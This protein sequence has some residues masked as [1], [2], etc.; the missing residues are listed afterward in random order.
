M[1]LIR[2]HPLLFEDV[3]SKVPVADLLWL[4]AARART[5]EDVRGI[6]R[7]LDDMSTEE[8]GEA[9]KSDIA[10]QAC[11]F[12]ADRCWLSMDA[13]PKEEQDWNAVLQVLEELE[14]LAQRHGLEELRYMA[15]QG[16]AVVLSDYLSRGN[17]GLQLLRDAEEPAN[18]NCLFF[19]RYRIARI[20]DDLN[21][22]KEAIDEY[23]RALDSGGRDFVYLRFRTYIEATVACGRIGNWEK[24]A[25]WARGGLAFASLYPKASFR[26]FEVH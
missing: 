8:L 1:R 22:T 7:V 19:V 2:E 15:L 10:P 9:L 18:Q 16:R 17:E 26:E 11:E 4:P 14:N 12:L 3:E 20:L 24:A 13:R 21:R 25:L 6:S 23:G 5:L